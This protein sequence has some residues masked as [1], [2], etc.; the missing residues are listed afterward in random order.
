MNFEEEKTYIF[1]P[2]EYKKIAKKLGAKR[3]KQDKLWYA[4]KIHKNY[5]ELVD[6]FHEDNFYAFDLEVFMK[7]EITTQSQRIISPHTHSLE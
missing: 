6:M 1:V 4:H 2:H 7:C 5:Q 3:S